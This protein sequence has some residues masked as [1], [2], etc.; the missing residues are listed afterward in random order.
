[1]IYKINPGKVKGRLQVVVLLFQSSENGDIGLVGFNTLRKVWLE[2]QE[3][4]DTDSRLVNA[5]LVEIFLR[6]DFRYDRVDC[7]ESK[8]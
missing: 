1:M 3:S 6:G 2:S 8:S 4:Y 7:G 5:E